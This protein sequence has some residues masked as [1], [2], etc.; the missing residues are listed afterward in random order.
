M[1]R[2][3]TPSQW[4]HRRSLRV[5]G[6]LVVCAVLSPAAQASEASLCRLA[7]QDAS[8]RTGVP[9]DVLLAITLAETGRSVGGKAQAWPWAMNTGGESHWFATEDELYSAAESRLSA[10]T[11]NIDLGCFQL[12]HRWHAAGFSSLHAMIDPDLNALYAA[13]FLADLYRETG[14]WSAA[15]AAYHSRTPEYADAYRARFET[16]LARV[17]GKSEGGSDP[18][19]ML[20]A[21]AADSP[22][23]AVNRFPLLRAGARGSAGSLVPLGQAGQRLIGGS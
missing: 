5:A 11:T 1:P 6:A 9:Q 10:G 3:V 2:F 13:R 14:D 8:A 23:P 21:D 7:A 18:A 20:L 12:N 4:L 22:V 17:Q 16:I 19:E 15:A